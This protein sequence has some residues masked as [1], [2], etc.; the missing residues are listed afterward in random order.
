[1]KTE[2]TDIMRKIEELKMR[3][4]VNEASLEALEIVKKFK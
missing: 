2:T 4:K 1:M 3:K